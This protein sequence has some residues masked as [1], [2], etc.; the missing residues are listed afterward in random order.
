MTPRAAR[1]SIASRLTLAL[2]AVALAVFAAVGLLLHWTLERELLRGEQTDIERSGEVVQHFVGE[3]ALAQDLAALRHHLDDAL[4]G[5]HRLRIWL[6]GADGGVVYGGNQRPRTEITRGSALRVRGENGVEMIGRTFQIDAAP[7]L[8]ATELIVALDTRARQRL[9][10]NHG[11][12]VALVCGLGVA[13]TVSLSA[14]TARRALRPVHRL[15]EEAAAIAPDALS[16]RLSEGGVA[17]ELAQL[18]AGFNLALDRVEAA[19]L[20]LEAFN[21]DVAHE[22]RTPL[23]T[24]I[25]GTEL[26][27]SRP[28][29]IDELRDTLASNLEDLRQLASMINDMLFL[30]RADRADAAAELQAVDLREEALRVAEFFDATLEERKQNVAVEG[31]ASTPANAALVRRAL[32][33]LLG[34]ACRYAPGG[35][36]IKIA[37]QQREGQVLL[38]VA[39]P[40]PPI[41]ADALPRLFDRFFRVDS[42]RT[43]SAD[44]HGLGLA[45]VRAIAQAHGGEASARSADGV[46]EVGFSLSLSPSGA[47]RTA[48]QQIATAGAVPGAP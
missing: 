13:I 38:T 24:L 19:Y 20:R 48:G 22:L 12:A 5:D 32:A 4:R 1:L 42:A 21:A 18:V 9:I 23:S 37:L 14:W 31:S 25:S 44:H 28:R 17:P 39:N 45:I 15:S 43:H 10:R 29:S 36:T 30:A 7:V 2:A 46:T 8:G 26:A 34:N 11:A 47:G 33:N 3:A 40:G 35:A 6:I 41:P 27:L 16:A